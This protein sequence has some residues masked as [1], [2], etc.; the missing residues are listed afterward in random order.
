MSFV[1]EPAQTYWSPAN[2]EHTVLNCVLRAPKGSIVLG[3]QANHVLVKR[4][5]MTEPF[6]EDDYNHFELCAMRLGKPIEDSVLLA[7]ARFIGLLELGA[8]L[9]RFALFL[10]MPVFKI[11]QDFNDQDADRIAKRFAEDLLK[12]SEGRTPEG[13]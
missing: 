3:V 1:I 9:M 5:V 11:Q 8:N 4:P 2:Q 7:G 10:N 13:A 6:S 12:A